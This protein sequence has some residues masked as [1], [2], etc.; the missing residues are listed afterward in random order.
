MKK[1]LFDLSGGV[2][3][4]IIAAVILMV[5]VPICAVTYAFS[6][7]NPQLILLVLLVFL[8]VFI[9]GLCIWLLRNQRNAKRQIDEISVAIQKLP[10]IIDDTGK[11]DGKG[12]ERDPLARQA[13]NE[14]DITDKRFDSSTVPQKL[15][16]QFTNR[17]NNLIRID[18]VRYSSSGTGIS[19][20]AI[21]PTYRKDESRNFIIPFDATKAEVNPDQ[22]FTIEICLAQKW[23]P[24]DINRF[25][26]N[27]GFL[28]M[29]VTYMGK[30]VE[31]LS[32]I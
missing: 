3:Q 7:A 16:I 23:D 17:G 6:T 22:E 2:L 9:A 8:Y 26:G 13:Q 24:K 12:K 4:N 25:S 14:L 31:I 10:R 20:A 5:L 29:D 11:A 30:L 28:K 32:M 21:L 15:I 19:D 27:W 1:W 18:K